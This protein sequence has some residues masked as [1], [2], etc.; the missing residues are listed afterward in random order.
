MS[1]GILQARAD[2]S[3]QLQALMESG[4]VDVPWSFAPHGK[5]LAYHETAGITQIWTVPLQEQGGWLKAGRPEPSFQST[6][7][8]VLPS[9][10][11]D[12]RWLVYH[13]N[14]SGKDEVYVRAFQTALGAMVARNSFRAQI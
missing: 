13:S 6:F 3:S 14:G 8:D 7:T 9:F 11:P 12:G 4:T 2:G 5:R 10:S 1:K